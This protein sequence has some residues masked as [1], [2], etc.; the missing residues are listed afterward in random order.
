MSDDAQNVIDMTAD[1]VSAYVGSNTT[2]AADLPALIRQVHD[3]LAGIVR[4][5]SAA[6]AAEPQKPAVPIR[7]S[8][9]PDYIICLEDG[10]PYKSLKR[11]LAASYGLTPQTYREKWGLPK[12]YPMVAAS[13]AASRSALAKST[14]LGQ[15]GRAAKAPAAKPAKARTKKAALKPRTGS[16]IT[17]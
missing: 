17:A 8:I 7:K 2:S 10:R 14:G 3:A 13:Y 12:D 5:E 15:G 6:P 9:T 11:H 16:E 4:G 1:I